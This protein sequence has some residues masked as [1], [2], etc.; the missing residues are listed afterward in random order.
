[1]QANPTKLVARVKLVQEEVAALKEL[2]CDHLTRR[3]CPLEPKSQILIVQGKKTRPGGER[4]PHW[5]YLREDSA[6]PT[7]KIPEP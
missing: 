4:P 7:E 6:S 3:R 5:Y 1:M 2:C